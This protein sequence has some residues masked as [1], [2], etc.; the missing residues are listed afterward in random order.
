MKVYYS[1][2]D[3]ADGVIIYDDIPFQDDPAAGIQVS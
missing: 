3:G 2:L 1:Q